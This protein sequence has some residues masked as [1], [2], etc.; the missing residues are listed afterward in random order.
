MLTRQ[1]HQIICDEIAAKGQVASG[2][3]A[4]RFAVSEDTIR[5][6][7]RT[8]AKAGQ[9]RR[10]YGG[11]V[12][13][14]AGPITARRDH[15]AEEKAQLARAAVRLLQPGQT[16]LFDAGSTNAAIAAALPATLPLTVA[17]NALDVASAV[18]DLPLVT[19]VLLGGTLSRETGALIGPETAG[20]ARNIAADAVF[21]GTC[22]LDPLHGITAFDPGEVA[23][24]QAMIA[25]SAR[26][27]V[28]ATAEKLGTA[29]PYRVTGPEGINDL[30]VT[31]EARDL[32]QPFNDQPINVHL[33]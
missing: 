15:Q 5:R 13:P 21:L 19:L 24:K 10:V 3:L 17:T 23:I 33:A 8:L 25:A 29:A 6:D 11:A 7:L 18:A 28:A 12:A 31:K 16:V 26:V 27:I 1:R 20:A 9:C 2:E 22:G 30:I 32:A 14:Y 4:Q